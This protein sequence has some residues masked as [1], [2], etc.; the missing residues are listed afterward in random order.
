MAADDGAMRERL[1]EDGSLFDGY[2]PLMAIVHRRNGDRLGRDGGRATAG[3]GR[4]WSARTA[5]TRRGWCCTTRSAIRRCSAAAC[6]C[7]S[8]RPRRARSRPGIRPRC[9]TASASTRGARRSTEACSTGTS[10]AAL[11]PWAIED[12]EGVD[13]RRAAV[14]LPPLADQVASAQASG[15][16]GGRPPTGRPGRSAGRGRALGALGRLARLTPGQAPLSRLWCGR[17]TPHATQSGSEPD[18]AGEGGRHAIVAARS[19]T[20]TGG[21]VVGRCRDWRS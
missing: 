7:S 11:A 1:V 13:E 5:P 18:S 9:S 17:A 2:N 6:R 21:R 19:G 12:A 8:R 4:R 10:R 20:V 14:G 15:R 3:R 16:A